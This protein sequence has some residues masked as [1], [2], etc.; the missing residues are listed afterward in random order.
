MGHKKWSE[1]KAVGKATALDREKARAELAEELRIARVTG[2]IES[3]ADEV[4]RRF[5]ESD[6]SDG[7]EVPV[8]E[9]LTRRQKLRD[10]NDQDRLG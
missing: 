7:H 10:G 1:I 2:E 8:A 5:E 3:S 9:H 4:A 6:P